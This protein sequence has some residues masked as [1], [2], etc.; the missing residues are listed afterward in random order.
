MF[1]KRTNANS[2]LPTRPEPRWAQ[3]TANT[4]PRLR[5]PAA[6]SLPSNRCRRL[7]P[8]RETS[9]RRLGHVHAPT[10]FSAERSQACCGVARDCPP[11]PRAPS[12]SRHRSRRL[13]DAAASRKSSLL[14][15][16]SHFDGCDP[17]LAAPHL[18]PN[19]K[20]PRV[21]TRLPSPRPAL[22]TPRSTAATLLTSTARAPSTQKPPCCTCHRLHK[23]STAPRPPPRREGAWYVRRV[24]LLK[25][26]P[27]RAQPRLVV[28]GVWGLSQPQ[29]PAGEPDGPRARPFRRRS[30][31]RM[32]PRAAPRS[33]RVML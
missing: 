31:L 22:T 33:R 19:F 32:Y 21:Q 7:P 29:K 16:D 1:S 25:R 15:A 4:Y 8:R 12:S 13:R 20:L 5:D 2:V 26:P 27:R 11:R 6:G 10:A 17:E 30:S 14:T 3:D 18:T 24:K 9:R 23:P 28:A